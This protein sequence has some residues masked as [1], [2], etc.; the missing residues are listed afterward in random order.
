M[1]STDPQIVKIEADMSKF[2]SLNVSRVANYVAKEIHDDTPVAS[3]YAASNWVARIGSPDTTTV[4]S[5]ESVDSSRFASSLV[6]LYRWTMGQGDIFIS[7]AVD[8]IG[9]LANGWSAQA[10][11]GFIDA[12]AARGLAKAKA[13]SRSDK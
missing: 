3:G 5:K 4:G 6:A 10:P 12:A 9:R 8:Y 11:S 1:A 7:N 2:I 13:A